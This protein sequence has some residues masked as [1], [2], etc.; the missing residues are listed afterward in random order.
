MNPALLLLLAGLG[1]QPSPKP[2]LVCVI[3]VD[4]LRPDYLDR[5]REQLNGGLALLL[6]RGASFTDAYQDHAV[7]ET[8]PGHSTILS[9]RWPAHTGI[10]RNTAGV[11]DSTAPLVGSPGPGASPVR[12][13]GTALFDWLQAAEPGARAL[14]VSGKDRGAILPLGRAKAQV[15]W[16]SYGAF[17]TSHY[18][19]DSLPTWLQTFNAQRVPFKA[20]GKAWTLL[21]PERAYHEPDSVSYENSGHDFTFPHRLPTDSNR[22]ALAFLATPGMDSLTLALALEGMRALQLGGRGT[23]DLLAVSLS[24]TDY[25]GHA[26]GPDSR[27]MH[28]QVIRLDRSLGW[29][30]QQLFVRYGSGNVDVVLTADHGITPFPERSRALG[31]PGAQRVVPDSVIRGVNA[32]LDARVGGADWF[33]F[34]SGMLLLPDRSKLAAL[35]VDVDSVVTAVAARL[36][37]LPGVTRVDRPG[38]LA[39]AD[40]TAA[41]VRRWVHSLPSDASV[42]L[43]VT[44][45]PYCIWSYPNLAIATHGQPNDFD[46]H[47]PL[48]FWG[49]GFRRGVYPGRVNTVDIAPTLARLLGLTPSEPLDGRVLTE[50]IAS[51][52]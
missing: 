23:T 45:Q 10:I 42:E 40:T 24:A 44:L 12:F 7:T 9:G 22:A 20:A 29:F 52:D 18:Y 1:A 47:V 50:A 43:V 51:Q 26:Y 27:E 16:Y 33:G 38:D 41:V 13:R 25:I 2:R 34:E 28:D 48:V 19:A 5:Y 21:L 4:Q 46:A 3:T 6:K 11:P 49:P 35:G 17:T 8:A 36:G 15:Y 39:R 14:S 32:A 31:H 37:A 30:L